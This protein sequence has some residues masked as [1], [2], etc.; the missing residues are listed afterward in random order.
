MDTPITVITFYKF[1]SF[2]PGFLSEFKLQL[3][4]WGQ[5][6]KLGGL[7]LIG[8]EG[9]NATVAGTANNIES[10]KKALVEVLKDNSLWFK[11]SEARSIPFS[12]FKV[13]IKDEI[14]TIGR[15]GLVPE[16]NVNHH[17]SPEEWHQAMQEE[18]VVVVDTRNQYETEIGIFKDALDLKIDDFQ[19]FTRKFEG[20]NFDKNKKVLIYCTGGIR[21][22]KAILELNE[23]GYKNVFQLNGGILNY[24]KEKPEGH[25]QGECFVFDHRVAVDKNLKASQTYALCPHCGQPGDTPIECKQC[26]AE[27]VVCKKCLSTSEDKQTCSKNC[28]NHF[29]LGNK[30]TKPHRDAKKFGRQIL[31]K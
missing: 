25:W 14:V 31:Y 20:Q 30:S 3:E 16:S 7:L 24:I 4:D 23:K 5:S 15:P 28:A 21:C 1:Q 11:D 22:E 10:F 6:Y 27:Q 12:R 18:D 26:E 2:D 17:L 13:K 8:P 19:E 29:R 9:I